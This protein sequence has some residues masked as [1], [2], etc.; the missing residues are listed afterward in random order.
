MRTMLPEE[1]KVPTDPRR[2]HVPRVLWP[3]LVDMENGW[4]MRH[5]R[6][7][8]RDVPCCMGCG[9]QIRVRE[10]DEQPVDGWLC[11]ACRESMA[12]RLDRIRKR[13]RAARRGAEVPA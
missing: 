11:L 8:L 6:G 9:R 1:E 12:A 3:V 7:R 2:R 10:G 13:E 5:S 4:Q